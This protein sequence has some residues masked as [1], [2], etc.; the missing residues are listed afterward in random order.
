MS[1]FLYILTRMASDLEDERTLQGLLQNFELR[2]EDLLTEITDL[3][4]SEIST[5]IISDDWKRMNPYLNM[6]QNVVEDM[7]ASFQDPLYKRRAYFQRWKKEKGSDANYKKIVLACLKCRNRRAAEDVLK[8][9]KHSNK[10][11]SFSDVQ[12]NDVVVFSLIFE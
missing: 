8:L 7:E 1:L 10:E 5:K 12:G 9:R 2:D 6:E 11:K 4:L 3:D